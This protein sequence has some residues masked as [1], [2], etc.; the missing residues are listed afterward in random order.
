[1]EPT[2][3]VLVSSRRLDVSRPAA[4]E[5]DGLRRSARFD[6]TSATFVGLVGRAF[7]AAAA[8]ADERE[9]FESLRPKAD[10]AAVAALGLAVSLVKGCG[11]RTTY[12]VSDPGPVLMNCCSKKRRG[13]GKYHQPSRYSTSVVQPRIEST[14]SHGL[15]RVG[16]GRKV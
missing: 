16:A 2:L 4:E 8:A 1:M 7:N 9:A 6:W 5:R 14:L 13:R 11:E 12:M 10:A 3:G 15:L